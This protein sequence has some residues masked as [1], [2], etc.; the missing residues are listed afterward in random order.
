MS[1]AT[2]IEAHSVTAEELLF[3]RSRQDGAWYEIDDGVLTLCEPAVYEHFDIG[4]ALTVALYNYVDQ[5]NL[6]RVFGDSAT[7]VLSRKPDTVRIPDVS[8]IRPARIPSGAA[9]KQFIQG[10]PDLAVE[11]M[12]PTDRMATV[13]RKAEQYIKAGTELVW[14]TRPKDRLVFVLRGDGSS[15]Q[16]RINGSLDGEG[17]IPGFRYPVSRLF[18][19]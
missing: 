16:L 2:N 9:I 13:E 15:Q 3:M 12:S 14:I 7:Y 19:R 10:P 4:T 6:G 5:H 11:I 18:M 17:V 8:F 1:H